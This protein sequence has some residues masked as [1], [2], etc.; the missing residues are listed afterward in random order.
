[1]RYE[2]SNLALLPVAA[3]ERIEALDVLRGFALFGVLL[4]YTLWNLGT[5]PAESYGQINRILDPVLAA[6]VDSKFYTLFAFLFGLGFSIQLQRADARGINIVPLYARRLL[7]LALIGLAH[8]LLL[9]NGDILVP[10]A[11]MG[12]FLLVFRRASNRTLLLAGII[13]ALYQEIAI[14][15]WHLSGISFPSPPET[16]R[17]SYLADNFAWLRY[18]YTT[19]IVYWPGCLPMFFFGLYLGRRRFFEK[20]ETKITTL[21]VALIIGLAIGASAYASVIFIATKFGPSPFTRLLW[22][23]HAYGLATC[24][25]STLLLLLQTRRGKL[26]TTP[27]GMVG[28]MALTNYLLQ[29]VIIVPICIELNLFDRVTP[30]LGLLLALIVWSMQVPFSV[31]W[32]RRFHF[33]PAEWLWRS[34]TYGRRQPMRVVPKLPSASHFATSR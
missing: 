26:W 17:A 31:W 4:A 34:I 22:H 2:N 23:I 29:A 1:M 3:T 9:R 24:Y 14:Y 19:S 21:R 11:V 33:G 16:G 13:A 15:G 27:L 30:D 12:I 20:L 8:A 28:R 6:L 7:G 32:L 10:Y 5:P 25:A 18:W